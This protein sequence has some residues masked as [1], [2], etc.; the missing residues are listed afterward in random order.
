M[1][2]I[3][4]IIFLFLTFSS[5]S[6]CQEIKK[7]NYF[8]IW[9][10]HKENININ[11]I[12]IGLG[13]FGD[14]IM[15]TNTN[16]IKIELIGLGIAMPLIPRSPIADND[17]TYVKIAKGPISEKINGISISAAGTACNCINN[18]L[19]F[20]LIGN[21]NFQVNGITASGVMNLT[22]KLNG[23]QLSAFNESYYMNGIQVGLTNHAG[24]AS[25]IQIGIYNKA[26]HLK[27]IQIGF[28]NENEKQK[29]PIINW[30]FK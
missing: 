20:G 23:I 25:G 1:K 3:Q 27:G 6:Y 12:S 28:W 24:R 18:G 30:N 13:S 7:K 29:F 26:K 21:L 11:G 15:N 19:N 17:S 14:K 22:Q 10:Y 16:G 8:P 4:G 9:T 2:K 5:F